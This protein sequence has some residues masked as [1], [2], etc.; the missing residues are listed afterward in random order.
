MIF[1]TFPEVFPSMT[2]FDFRSH[3]NGRNGCHIIEVE[4]SKTTRISF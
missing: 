1:S 4:I 3:R 2:N